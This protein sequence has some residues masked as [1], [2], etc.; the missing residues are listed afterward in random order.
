[1]L[2][3]PVDQADEDGLLAVGGDLSPQ[4]LREAYSNGIFPWPVEG[5]PLLWFAPPQRA[6]LFFDELKINRRLGRTFRASNFQARFDTDFDSVIQACAAPR[7][8]DGELECGTWIT[9]QMQAAYK[10][11]HRSGD[12]SFRARSVETWQN[13][14]LV[15]GLYGVQIG[16][17]FCGESMFHRAPDASKFALVALVENLKSRGASW[18]DVEMPTPHFTALGAR[19]IARPEFMQMLRESQKRE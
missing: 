13:D 2:F 14:E 5:Y 10:N 11:L 1:M 15:G 4:F 19:Q 6:I 7:H 12:E 3:P 8:V 17:Y 18:L 16:Q 9:P